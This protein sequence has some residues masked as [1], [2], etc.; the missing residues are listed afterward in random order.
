MDEPVTQ[1]AGSVT[2]ESGS[3]TK[4][5]GEVEEF[6]S[7]EEGHAG[8]FSFRSALRIL[9]RQWDATSG[10]CG[11]HWAPLEAGDENLAPLALL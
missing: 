8:L 9:F 3:V 5:E 7:Y 10:P 6:E 4:D 1:E 2:Q 11:G